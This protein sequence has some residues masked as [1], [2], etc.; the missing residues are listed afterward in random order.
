MQPLVKHKFEKKKFERGIQSIVSYFEFDF[1]L[2]FTDI[3]S[4][5][6]ICKYGDFVDF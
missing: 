6:I 2:Y 1:F 3:N 5:N 4:N